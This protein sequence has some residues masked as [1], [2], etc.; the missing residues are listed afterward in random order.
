[1]SI[2]LIDTHASKT[3]LI[4]PMYSYYHTIKASPVKL[5]SFKIN[6]T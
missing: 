5:S 2:G 4:L 3:V 6:K 1:M